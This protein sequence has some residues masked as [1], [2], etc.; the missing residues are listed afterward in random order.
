[1]KRYDSGL[2]GEKLA[3]EWLCAR[4]MVCIDRRVRAVDGELDLVMRDGP[5]IVFV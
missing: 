5:F 2:L 3:E 4:G 1:M